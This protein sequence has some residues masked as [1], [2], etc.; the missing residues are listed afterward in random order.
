MST[1][2]RRSRRRIKSF[3]GRQSSVRLPVALAITLSMFALLIFVLALQYGANQAEVFTSPW[4][5]KCD[6]GLCKK[7]L[8]TEQDTNP[9]A[10]SVCQL[11]CGQ[12][13]TL[14]PM[15]TGH[16]SVGKTVV[17]LNPENIA[18]VGISTQTAVG[19]LLQRNVV[20][21]KDTARKLS[22]PVSLNAGGTG[23]VIRFAEGL[24]L[25]NVKLTLETNES[26]T[27]RVSMVDQQVEAYITAKTYF[28]ARYAMETLSQLIVFDDLRN[29]IQ[30]ATDAYI[31]DG[32][33]YPY[34][35]ILLDTSRNYVDKETILR[36]I[37]GIAMSKLNT[38]HWHITD[39][40]SFPYVSRTW[41][42]FVKY[43][44][45]TP[46]KIYTPEMIREIVD[47]ALVRGVRVLPEFDAPAHVGEGWQWVGDNATVCFKA[48][49]WKDF[50][51]EPPCGQL[52]PTSEKMYEVLEG[53]YK[54]MI[55][56]F[57]QPDIF[58][59]G[60]DEVNV[61]CWR[62]QKIITDWMQK[63][64]WDLSESSF[65][66]LW[67]YFQE[68]AMEKLKIANGGKDIP[69]VL[70][71]SGLTSEE[72]LKHLDP[73]K[74]IIQIWTTGFDLTIGRLL[75]NNFKIIFSNYDALYLDCGFGAWV[76]EGNNWCAPYKGWQKIYDNSPLDMVKKQGYGNKKHLILGGEAA[77]WTEQADSANTDSRLWPRSAAMAERLWS[78]PDSKWHHAEQRMLRQR[79]RFIEQKIYADTLEPEWCLQNQG[80]CYA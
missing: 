41:P 48:E 58:H 80:S 23:L 71:T 69:A 22:G 68:R 57:Q 76:G 28:G 18:L 1:I 67:D 26:Y 32:P 77:L 53:I 27:L 73:A 38:F 55:E 35:G 39:S 13:G 56:D 47:Y 51:V 34:R 72:N 3:Y 61:N 62:S 19:N 33:K 17:Q 42:D 24:D 65:Y 37:D 16:M 79:E 45:Y 15:P 5:Y 25:S 8:I 59:M 7:I 12:G 46:T 9:A 44:S 74:Y 63:K 30:V 21:M 4:H 31:V 50:C 66:L 54:D 70:W 2:F 49:P 10:L 14:W 36:T 40:Q 29:K 52:N 6:G 43:G 20:R 78:E 64:G 75:Q 60:G 11:S